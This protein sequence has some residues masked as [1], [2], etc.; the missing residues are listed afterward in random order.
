MSLEDNKNEKT[1][2][3]NIIFYTITGL[4]FLFHILGLIRLKKYHNK[5]NN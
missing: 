5:K 3:N 2:K 4:I 1:K